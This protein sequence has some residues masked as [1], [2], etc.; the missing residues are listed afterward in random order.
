MLELQLA[1]F[2]M[3]PEGRPAPHESGWVAWVVVGLIAVVVVAG[4][5]W[6]VMAAQSRTDGEEDSDDGGGGL[7]R[8]DAGGAPRPPQ[9]PT[10]GTDPEWWPEFEREFAAHVARHTTR[11]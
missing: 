2:V 10:A 3:A 9:P 5:W 1:A 7:R 8:H 4:K 6:L 11:A